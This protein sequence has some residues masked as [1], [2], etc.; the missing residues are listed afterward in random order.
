MSVAATALQADA[1]AEASRRHAANDFDGAAEWYAAALKADSRHA[2]ALC[3]LGQLC[4][5]AGELERAGA[6]YRTAAR[7]NPALAAPWRQLAEL[8]ERA[9]RTELALESY[10][11]AAS[12]APRDLAT[13]RGLGNLLRVAGRTEEALAVLQDAAAADPHDKQTTLYLGAAHLAAGRYDDALT[14]FDRLRAAAPELPE[15]AYFAAVCLQ[16]LNRHEEAIPVIRALMTLHAPRKEWLSL[17]GSSYFRL[18]RFAESAAALRDALALDP[19]DDDTAVRVAESFAM[20][21]DYA[22]ALRI[23]E[24]VLAR[25]PNHGGAL[26]LQVQLLQL[27]EQK[28]KALAICER[29]LSNDPDHAFAQAQR[30]AIRQRACIWDGYD[31]FIAD[32]GRYIAAAVAAKKPMQLT[33]QDLHNLPLPWELEVAAA[34]RTAE[35]VEEQA[36]PIRTRLRFSFDARIARARAGEKRKLRIGYTLPYTKEESFTILHEAVVAHHDHDRF[37]VFAYAGQASVGTGFD[38]R[39]RG[40]FDAVRDVSMNA[41]ERAA[42]AVYDDQVDVLLDATG[43]TGE[44]LQL[45]CA[46]RPAPVVAQTFGYSITT[47]ASYVDYLVTD[48]EFMPPAMGALCSETLVYLPD[49]LLPGYRPA[50]ADRTYTRTDLNLPERGFVFTDFNQPFKFEPSMFAAWM[51]VLRRVPGSVLW[52]GGWDVTARRNLCIE[53]AHQDVAPERLV[54]AD[55][56]TRANHLA[57]LRQADLVLDTRY[58]SGGATTLDALWVGVPL[59]T[60]ADATPASRNGASFAR[61]LGMPEMVTLSLQ[62][63]EDL[64]VRVAGDPALHAAWR[65]TVE[66]KRT[67]AALFDA[68][69]FTR[70]FERAITAMWEQTV[71]GNRQPIDLRP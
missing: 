59:V 14:L 41:P 10:R 55:V 43:H 36:A 9:G 60:L 11:Q 48:A 51:R 12:R 62:E 49:S 61:A 2:G 25:S 28:D 1:F 22:K 53:A 33:I 20:L 7:S 18:G 16:T 47:G 8:Q 31:A 3:G 64:A 15:P 45:L 42:Q 35:T 67:S 54:F 21:P 24:D 57:R 19:S 50:V 70:N 37:E 58:H 46:L 65:R 32:T 39:Y 69:R 56:A 23:V 29:M 44:N 30:V 6:F 26:C 13:L 52:L 5:V 63:F 66:A 27:F 38:A 34:R 68:P 40:H 71:S 17:L 4:E